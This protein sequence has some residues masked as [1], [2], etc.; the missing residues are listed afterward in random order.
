MTAL[1]HTFDPGPWR[2]FYLALQRASETLA[3]HERE[4]LHLETRLM[5]TRRALES[6][7]YLRGPLAQPSRQAGTTASRKRIRLFR[8]RVAVG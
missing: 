6:A 3:R 4:V 8:L 7:G 5:I 2:A 1:T